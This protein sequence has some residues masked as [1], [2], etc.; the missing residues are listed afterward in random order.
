[1]KQASAITNLILIFLSIGSIVLADLS[2]EYKKAVY[3]I[4]PSLHNFAEEKNN[5]L[6]SS[7]I[8]E[9]FD[10]Y[11]VLKKTYTYYSKI[12]QVILDIKR[13]PTFTVDVAIFITKDY[14][15]ADDTFN[16][17]GKEIKYKYKKEMGFGQESYLYINPIDVKRL[18]ANFY[19]L[20]KNQNFIIKITSDDGFAIMD[21]TEYISN[22][23]ASFIY[24]NI[25]LYSF[26]RLRVKCTINDKTSKTSDILLLNKKY[27]ELIIEGTIKNANLEDIA[28]ATVELIELGIKTKSDENG[29]FV[30]KG[31]LGKSGSNIKLTKNF[32]FDEKSKDISPY[33]YELYEINVNYDN[34]K[35]NSET[36]YL[37]VNKNV[38][39]YGDIYSTK[40]K[41]IEPVKILAN[42][43]K[44]IE[45]IRDC[46]TSIFS[47]RQK[48]NGSNINGTLSGK[49]NGFGGGGNFIGKKVTSIVEEKVNLKNNDL[50]SIGILI[51]KQDGTIHTSYVGSLYSYIYPEEK[52]YVLLHCNPVNKKL[53]FLKDAYLELYHLPQHQLD[54][55]N[56]GIYYGTTENNKLVLYDRSR[57]YVIKNFN[58]PTKIKL[59]I[60]DY[61]IDRLYV[62]KDLLIG[63]SEP[64]P[65][66]LIFGGLASPLEFNPR[67]VF[68]NFDINYNP[69]Q[70]ATISAK[71]CD[72]Q[73]SDFMSRSSN[74]SDNG[75]NDICLSFDLKNVNGT[76]KDMVITYKSNYDFI[77][78][79]KEDDIYPG[80]LFVKNGKSFNMKNYKF[81]G[82]NNFEVYISKPDFFEYAG[83]LNY[84]IYIDGKAYKGGVP[85]EK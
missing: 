81:E 41:Q 65:I 35:G 83:S 11:I 40:N 66:N 42:D 22:N 9:D 14:M 71:L 50:C 63:I 46:S 2:P 82:N 31:T 84:L 8:E 54:K 69:A 39:N 3:N 13:D 15:T 52:S 24:Q 27:K 79:L 10:K 62:D 60:T 45:F 49:W 4:F 74:H 44:K 30:L 73:A 64:A 70:N 33:D 47:C 1:M 56:L 78:N 19:T 25:D 68:A 43:T 37:K 6:D 5:W 57:E 23:L 21:F 53:F 18:K 20:T 38:P 34:D 85:L 67:I 72:E 17:L 12:S 26:N 80:I 59:N 55:I 77:W 7:I 58:E 32:I 48:F 76:F 29:H 51:E 16:R 75:K 61:L 28:G 36:L